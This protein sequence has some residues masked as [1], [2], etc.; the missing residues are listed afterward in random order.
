MG[1]ASGALR[2]ACGDAGIEKAR[3]SGKF[4]SSGAVSEGIAVDAGSGV[5]DACGCQGAGD[6]PVGPTEA[7]APASNSG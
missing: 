5:Q 1:E 2:G 6:S 4:V 3:S 7:A